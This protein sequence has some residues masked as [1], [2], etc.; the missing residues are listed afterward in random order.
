MG[1]I[2]RID[3]DAVTAD[4]ARLETEEI[5]FGRRGG[6]D[7]AGGNAGAAED[8]RDL[9]DEG[10]VDVALGIFDNFCRFRRS[11]VLGDENAAGG[12]RPIKV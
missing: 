1:Q 2:E 4:Q 7:I 9:I 10:D 8:H 12:N 3:A 5:P 11:D 6:Q